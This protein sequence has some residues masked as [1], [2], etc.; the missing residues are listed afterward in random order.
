MIYNRPLTV[1]T[2]NTRRAN[3]YQSAPQDIG[4]FFERLH[5]SQAIPFDHDA[6]KALPKSQ[7]DDLK[8]VGGFV[9]GE[10]RGGRRKAGAVLSRCAA[11]LDADN[12]GPGETENAVRRVEALGCGYCIYSTAKHSQGAPRLRIVIPFSEDIPADEHEPVTRLL[13]QMIQPEMTWFDPTTAEPSRMMYY[14]AHCQDIDPVYYVGDKPL[15][16]TRA[17]LSRLKD[18]R[19]VTSWPRFPQEQTPARLAAKQGDPETKHGVVGA[20]CRVYDVPAAMDKFLPGV[21]EETDT[22]GRYTFTGGSTTGG[23]VLYD[24]GKFLYSHHATDPCGGRLVNAFDLVRLHRFEGL[25]DEAKP[26]TPPARLPSWVAMVKLAKTDEAVSEVLAREA[27]DTI[28]RGMGPE[29]DEE[30]AIALG[31]YEGELLTMDALRTTLRAF[32]ISVRFNSVTR[33]VEIRGLSPDYSV[34]NAANTLPVFLLDT[35]KALRMKNV[36]KNNVTDY[37]ANIADINRYNPVLE[38][39]HR[40]EWDR[41]DRLSMILRIMGVEPGSFHA[42]LVKKW[43]VQGVALAHN[44]L[45]HIEPSSGVLTLQGGQQI[46]KT[47]LIRRIAVFSEWFVE[48]ATLDMRNKDDIIRATGAWITELGEV[49]STLQ[50]EQSSLKAFITQRVDQ[51]RAPYARESTYTPRRTS[52]CA[53]VNPG[54]FLRDDTGDLRFWVV[55]T[56]AIDLKTLFSLPVEWF[57]QLWAEAFRWWAENPNSFRLT[58]DEKKRLDVQNQEFRCALPIEEDIRQAMD[59]TLPEMEWGEFSA[60]ELG[61]QL[62]FMSYRPSD[63]GRI[64]RVLSKLAREDACITRRVLHGVPRYRLPIRRTIRLLGAEQQSN[65]A[66]HGKEDG[67]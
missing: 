29:T 32:G 52:F 30:A 66:D 45:E 67:A 9:L 43:L 8:D 25:D 62:F 15:L 26:G 13:C 35:L 2:T 12:L 42:M 7:Q 51:I 61:R 57:M 36:T 54:Q 34:E 20:F 21:Y 6:Y 49:D 50:K 19:D 58:N 59:G 1:Y 27:F 33:R 22:P 46:G 28:A 48:G 11:V 5:S 41:M 31:R 23:A 44:T 14:P 56:P 37:L 16:D 47:S 39:L 64:G 55:P 24:G 63:T 10:L 60:S 17:L 65:G 18:W 4:Q 3:V 38:M 53:T 40:V